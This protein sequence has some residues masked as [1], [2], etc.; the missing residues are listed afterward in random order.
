MCGFL[1]VLCNHVLGLE[2]YVYLKYK[3][4]GHLITS[5]NWIQAS[6]THLKISEE[7]KKDKTLLLQGQIN[8][9][10]FQKILLYKTW[11]N[12]DMTFLWQTHMLQVLTGESQHLHLRWKLWNAAW[13][14]FQLGEEAIRERFRHR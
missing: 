4:K 5:E 12:S 8:E 11:S 9:V 6:I 13:A 10:S 1:N 3:K 2:V 14:V 7:V